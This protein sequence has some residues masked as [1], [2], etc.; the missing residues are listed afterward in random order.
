MP[1]ASTTPSATSTP[2]F[3]PQTNYSRSLFWQ[4]SPTATFY[5]G[6]TPQVMNNDSATSRPTPRT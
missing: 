5:I 4:F 6:S 2:A 3:T 1:S